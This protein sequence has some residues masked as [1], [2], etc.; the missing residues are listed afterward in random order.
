MAQV[1]ALPYQMLLHRQARESMNISLKGHV[2][3]LDEAH[4]LVD[5]ISS[6]Y[7]VTLSAVAVATSESQ[8]A[9]YHARYQRR[10]SAVNTVGLKE[11]ALVLGALKARLAAKDGA[12]ASPTG[13]EV[14]LRDVDF[15]RQLRL[16]NVN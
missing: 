11:L 12:E 3:L 16:D 6:M 7:S 8:L 1:V 15:L 4:N 10:L 13:S 14:M 2:I 9:Q 5:A